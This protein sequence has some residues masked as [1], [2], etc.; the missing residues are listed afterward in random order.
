MRPFETGRGL[1]VGTMLAVIM[2]SPN[3]AGAETSPRGELED[4]FGRVVTIRSEATTAKQARD[5]VRGLARALFDGRTAS[6]QALGGTWDQRTG[7]ERDEFARAFTDVLERAYIDIVQARLPRDRPP[8]IRVIGE[9]ISG[10]RLAVVR[11]KV[12]TRDGGDVQLDYKMNR[13]AK[14]WL[15]RDIVI[16]GVS[17]V[18]NYRAQFARVLRRA[19]YA[20]LLERLRTVA[21]T[22]AE[23][24]GADR[25]RSGP[26]LD[27]LALAPLRPPAQTP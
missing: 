23:R 25:P 22:G 7:A 20:E 9:N 16:D 27:L 17:L 13:P 14:A 6:R 2:L 26:G 3:L 1:A 18:E 19:S 24:T 21:G 8:A 15:I 5:D 12:E 10:D 11:T 4:F